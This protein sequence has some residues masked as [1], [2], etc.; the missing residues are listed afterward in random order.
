[1]RV[2][3]VNYWEPA[4]RMRKRVRLGLRRDLRYERLRLSEG[5]LFT[6]TMMVVVMM[7]MNAST[8][9]RKNVNQLRLGGREIEEK[10]VRLRRDLRHET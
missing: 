5:D 8:G 6:M 4:G 7:M 3:R 9:S 2:V 10:Y 1:M